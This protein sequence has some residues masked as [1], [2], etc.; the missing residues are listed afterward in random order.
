MVDKLLFIEDDQDQKEIIEEC[1]GN[2][3]FQID[4]I[5]ISGK[6]IPEIAKYFFDNKF[7]MIIADH[8]LSNACVDFS[9][10]E[11]I[12]YMFKICP[13]LQMLV[14]TAHEG[15]AMSSSDRPILVEQRPQKGKGWEVLIDKIRRAISSYKCQ[16]DESNVLLQQLSEKETLTSEEQINYM[17]ASH[18]LSE[19]QFNLEN[20]VVNTL[21]GKTVSGKV[22]E[23]A[24]SLKRIENMLEG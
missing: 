2:Q 7:H 10:S 5:K 4:F 24:E 1:L 11:F 3:G 6:T 21:K 18:F 12:N 13:H 14:L 16:I 17:R 8:D 19:I 20:D 15:A 22:A 9:G 23:I